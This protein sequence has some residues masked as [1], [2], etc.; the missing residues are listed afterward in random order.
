MPGS[1]NW[2]LIMAIAILLSRLIFITQLLKDPFE[3][4]TQSDK[5]TS[6]HQ[7]LNALGKNGTWVQDWEFARKFG[8]H[9][10]PLVESY[11]PFYRRTWGRFKPTAEIPFPW[12][13]SWRWLD[14][15]SFGDDCQIDYT[16]GGESICEALQALN[17]THLYFNGDS[18]TQSQYTS[19]INK[20]GSQYVTIDRNSKGA[21]I[22]CANNTIKVLQTREGQGGQAFPSSPRDN[23]TLTQISKDFFRQKGRKLSIWNMGAHYHQDSHYQEDIVQLFSWMEE[24]HNKDDLIFFRT[25]PSGHLNC[26]PRRPRRFNFSEYRVRP[27]KNYNEFKPTSMHTWEKFDAYNT[28]TKQLLRERQN[29]SSLEDRPQIRL[30]DVVNMTLLRPD[31]H[32]GGGDCLHYVQPGP[33]DWWNHLLFTHLV[34]IREMEGPLLAGKV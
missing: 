31:G 34:K 28:Y 5:D 32:S 26:E 6:I 20:L 25:T 29:N 8:Q 21:S 27:L 3:N 30:L 11:G 22:L 2:C 23:I 10:I 9:V 1:N 18:M 19:F 33:I 17:I 12:Q 24:Y 16:M 13:T 15:N 7:C 4:A 14:F